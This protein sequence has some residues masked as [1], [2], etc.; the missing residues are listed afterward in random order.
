MP[1]TDRQD[2]KSPQVG[3]RFPPDEMER[4]REHAKRR[5]ANNVSTMVKVAVQRLIESDEREQ[6]EQGLEDAA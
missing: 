4:L 2:G 3:V 5:Y 6:V 1:N